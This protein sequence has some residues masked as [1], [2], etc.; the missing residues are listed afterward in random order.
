MGTTATT[1]TGSRTGHGVILTTGN[2]GA[3]WSS[4]PLSSRVADLMD[5]S[6]TAVNTC[7]S[8]GSSVSTATQAGVVVLT[9]P[10]PHSWKHAA[11]V[12]SPQPLSA[13][14]CVSTAGCVVVGESISEHLT[15]S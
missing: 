9:G 5:V 12:G 13:V 10:D 6:C 8:V 11:A 14:S 2:G 4:E 3:T 1:L 7:V 15:A